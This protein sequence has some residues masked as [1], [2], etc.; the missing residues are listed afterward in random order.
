V[1]VEVRNSLQH[2]IH[3]RRAEKDVLVLLD[4]NRTAGTPILHS[5]S[6]VFAVWN[7]RFVSIA[8]RAWGPQS[9]VARM[10]WPTQLRTSSSAVCAA[11][12]TEK[13]RLTS[14]NDAW[15]RKWWILLT[16]RSRLAALE[17]N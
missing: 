16:L 15:A 13:T 5:F 9:C 8:G 7:R 2:T 17:S 12:A 3:S 6:G 11:Q 1:I 14:L 4:R 10:A